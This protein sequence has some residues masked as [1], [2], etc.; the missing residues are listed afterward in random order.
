MYREGRWL[1][2]THIGNEVLFQSLLH[3]MNG[4]CGNTFLFKGLLY[5]YYKDG[6]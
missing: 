2:I 1:Y 3:G 4:N 6:E 5:K